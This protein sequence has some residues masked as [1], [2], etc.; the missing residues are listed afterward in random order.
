MNEDLLKKVI[1]QMHEHIFKRVEKEIADS[2]FPGMFFGVGDVEPPPPPIVSFGI[3]DI[4]EAMEKAKAATG[5]RQRVLSMTIIESPFAFKITTLAR[6]IPDSRK[7]NTRRPLYRKVRRSKP[8][9]YIMKTKNT[10]VCHPSI[11]ARIRKQFKP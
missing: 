7:P 8:M 4:K 11:A 5:A 9:A 3:A 10:L 6:G 1:D 2:I